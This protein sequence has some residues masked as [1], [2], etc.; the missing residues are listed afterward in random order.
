[1]GFAFDVGHALTFLVLT[2]DTRKVI[3]RSVLQLAECPENEI[4]LDQNNLHLDKAAGKTIKRKVNFRTTGRD[5]CL[6]DGFI[7]K[8]IMP[9]TDAMND[10]PPPVEDQEDDSSVDT[11]IITPEPIDD[12]P[13]LPENMDEEMV[14]PM[15]ES[16]VTGFLNSNHGC[17]GKKD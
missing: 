8:T 11:E 9:N 10:V 6:A 13:E 14:N 16:E 3:K 4:R 15:P 5:P 1:M 7:M 17:H 12:I 2:D